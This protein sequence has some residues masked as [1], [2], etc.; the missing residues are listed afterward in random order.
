MKR[1]KT[2]IRYNLLF[3]G[4]LAAVYWL[5]ARP[6]HQ[7][8]GA[9]PSEISMKLP[10][11]SLIS[12]QQIVSTRAITIDAPVNRVWP[13]IVQTGQNRGGFHSYHWLENLF[14]A[15]MVNAPTIHP[16]WQHPKPGDTVYFGKDQPFALLSLVKENEYFSI[17]GWTFYLFTT[18]QEQ[19]RMIIRY[20]SMKVRGSTLNT[21]YYY[22]LFEPAHF[23][24]EAGMMMGIK[25]KAEQNPAI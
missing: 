4:L 12:P 7:N 18:G 23:I 3:Y 5:I 16:E 11:D 19:T 8:W 10:A 14:G 22:G 20:P 21:I 13:W 9:S 1:I 17:G 15:K 2:F 24:M 25:R 6:I